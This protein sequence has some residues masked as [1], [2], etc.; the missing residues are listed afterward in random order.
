MARRSTTTRATS[1]RRRSVAPAAPILVVNMIPKSL[2][3]EAEQDSEPSIAVDPADPQ[4]IVATAFT[5][6]PMGTGFAPIYVSADGGLTWTLRSTVPSTNITGDIS[7][8][9]GGGG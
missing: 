3:G 4:R 5:P 6:D 9:F 8:G 7:V 2:S 1:R